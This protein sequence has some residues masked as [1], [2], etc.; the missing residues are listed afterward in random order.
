MTEPELRQRVQEHVLG[1]DH[2]V[3]LSKFRLEERADA[4]LKQHPPV[5]FIH[6]QTPAS[7]RDAS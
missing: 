7:Q 5:A 1:L 2:A 6:Q 4:G 3:A